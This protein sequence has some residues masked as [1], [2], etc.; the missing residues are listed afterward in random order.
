MCTQVA[1]QP[2]LIA[3][4]IDLYVDERKRNVAF[5]RHGR[6][7]YGNLNRRAHGQT[8]GPDS[9]C[10]LLTLPCRH[11]LVLIYLNLQLFLP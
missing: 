6:L 5:A 2:F 3:L 10:D 8:H 1:N 9:Q 11:K 7:V 4:Q